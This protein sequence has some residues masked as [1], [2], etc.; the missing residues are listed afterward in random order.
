MIGTAFIQYMLKKPKKFGTKLWVLCEA[1]TRFC[2]KFQIYTGKAEGGQE[3]GLAHRVVFDLMDPFLDL[4]HRSYFDNF[5]STEKLFRDL[6]AIKTYACGTIRR[7]RG[8]FLPEFEADLER[9]ESTI[10][11]REI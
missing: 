5:Y 2:L 11:N 6:D 1:V 8:R 3:K 4:N 10:Y 7:D 9:G